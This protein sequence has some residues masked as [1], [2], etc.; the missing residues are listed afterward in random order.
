MLDPAAGRDESAAARRAPALDGDVR[1]LRRRSTTPTR[2][3]RSTDAAAS[4]HGRRRGVVVRTYFAHHQ[5][6]T[7]VALANVLLGDRD[8]ASASTPTRAC[9]RPSSCCRSACRATRRRSQPRP[10]R[11][12]ARRRRRRR[13]RRRAA[14][15][16]PHT[17][18]PHA[19]F[20]SN[21]NYVTV[22]TNAGGGASFWRG[23]AVDAVA[24]TT[25]R[26]IPAASS[27]TCATCAAAPSGRPTYQP[28]A[29]RAATTT[30]SRSA[31]DARPS[32]GATTT[33]RR[34]SRSP[35]RPKTTSRCAGS[36]VTNHGDRDAR[37]RRH[38]LRRDRA[39]AAGRRPRAPGV[40]QAV[41][42]DRVPA[43]ERGAALPPPAARRRR[44][45]ALGRP[46]PQ[47]R[48]PAA[49]AGRVGDR[50]RALPRPRPRRRPTRSR[51]T[52]ARC[53]ARPASCSIRSSAC[54]SASG[55]RRARSRGSSFATGVAAD[56]ET[57]ARARAEVP[58]PERGVARLRARASRTRR[59]RLRHLG[60]SPRRRAAVRA[61]RV[62]RALR[63]RIARAPAPD[64]HRRER[65][66]A[67]P[68]LWPHGISG[69][70]PILLVRVVARR[71]PRARAA[72]PAGAGVLAPQGPARRRRHPERASG[73][74]TST[75]STT[76]LT[77]LLDN[78]PWRALE[79]PARRRLSCCAATASAPTRERDAARGGRARGPRAATAATSRAQL[80]RA[81]PVGRRAAG[82]ARAGAA[83]GRRRRPPTV[84]A[85]APR[86]SANGLGG[87]TDDGR[88]VRDRARGR[89]GDAAARGSNVIANPHFGTIVTASGSALHLVGEQ[90]REPADAVRQRS[91][92]RSDRRGA[93]HPR[94]RDR[95][96]PGRRR[97]ARWRA[98]PTSGRFVVRHAAGRH[99][100]L[101]HAVAASATSS[102][103]SSTRAIR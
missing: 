65:R 21:G 88:D 33:S 70:L 37:D 1:L 93:L 32:A 35:S 58:R 5:G 47:P 75:R 6:M 76:Q 83:P 61:A 72:G 86:R 97:R 44:A 7:L 94:R 20:L 19:Q 39:R 82:A 81:A 59:A 43:A 12:D 13:P 84:A 49:G 55:S 103:S 40:R 11:R 8:G 25:R 27:S 53:R 50:P 16:S 66:S 15:R 17:A 60:I 57:A 56:R 41:P 51:S 77:A 69:D 63:R 80:D 26:A 10:A 31:R 62:A 92:H 38:Q 96:R 64:V 52:A 23:L 46:R 24:A 29:A 100:L 45:A 18:F 87:F 54:A 4:A 9:R 79:A 89:P 91:G 95:R 78:G 101:A 67:Q 22:V 42:R 74:A 34:S 28:D 98:R 2:D 3:T 99:A 48:G 85:A 68:A 73:R 71:R 14:I 30:S 102:T 36:T 90:P